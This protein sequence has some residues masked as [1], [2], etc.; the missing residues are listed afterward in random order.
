MQADARIRTVHRHSFPAN[1][2]EAPAE[3]Q[4]NEPNREEITVN[5]EQRS[6]KKERPHRYPCVTE[7]AHRR[8]Y[9]REKEHSR[10]VD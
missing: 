3:E 4:C 2:M 7:E 6:S 8:S 1:G 9:A 10:S 5:N